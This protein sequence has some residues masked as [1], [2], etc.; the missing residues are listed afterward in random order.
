MKNRF[1]DLDKRK[2]IFWCLTIV[3]MAVIFIFSSKDA[4][5]STVESHE[6][7]K[8]IGYMTEYDFPQWT[9]DAQERYAEKIDHPIRKTAHFLEY[10]LLGSLFDDALWS[11]IASL[12]VTNSSS[13][14]KLLK[15]LSFDII[16]ADIIS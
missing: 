16:S 12:I 1:K 15:F 5:T 9:P 14:K 8:F 7:G 10:M 13:L 3:W 4:D 6:V 11:S 2:K